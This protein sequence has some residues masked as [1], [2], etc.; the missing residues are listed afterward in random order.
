M[1]K[2]NCFSYA[3]FYLSLIP[4]YLA[5]KINRFLNKCVHAKGLFYVYVELS[6]SIV[7]QPVDMGSGSLLCNVS[8]SMADF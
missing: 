4:N 8:G 2:L 3:S 1:L 7:I 5:G 6:S